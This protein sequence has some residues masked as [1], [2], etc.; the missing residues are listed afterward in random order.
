M[1]RFIP[2]TLVLALLGSFGFAMPAS[3]QVTGAPSTPSL[4]D[5][6]EAAAARSATAPQPADTVAV[7]AFPPPQQR[8]PAALLPLYISFGAL[9]VLDARFTVRA[10]D[11][12]AVEAN[13]LMKGL[14]S[15]EVG[16]LSVKAAATAGVIYAN[17]LMWKRNKTAA[18]FFMIATN[19][20]M[21]W[22][23]QHNYRAGQ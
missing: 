23:V 20:A 5:A 11:G 13:P 21:A 2:L 17:E 8:R 14:A 12:G 18:V 10:I 1:V 4:R 3:A 19:S 16:M 22:V 15:N 7:V 9:Q 6:I